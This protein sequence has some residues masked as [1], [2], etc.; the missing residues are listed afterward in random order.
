MGDLAYIF[1]FIAPMV[2]IA[3][4]LALVYFLALFIRHR[5]SNP[6]EA[7]RNKKAFIISLTVSVIVVVSTWLFLYS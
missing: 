1:L 4:P 7:S 6:I 5:K 2:L 3:T